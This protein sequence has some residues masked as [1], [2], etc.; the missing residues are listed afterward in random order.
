MKN[1]HPYQTLLAIIGNT[2]GAHALVLFLP[3]HKNKENVCLVSSWCPSQLTVEN[4]VIESG[5]GYIGWVARNSSP[6]LVPHTDIHI[7]SFG[8]YGSKTPDIQ[9]FLAIPLNGGGVLAMDSLIKDDF[10]EDVQKLFALFAQLIPQLQ[11]ISATSSLSLQVSTYFYALESLHILRERYSS[12]S[13]YLKSFLNIISDST[14]FEYVSFASCPEDAKSYIVECENLPLIIKNNEP[15]ELPMQTGM[16]GWVLKN[17]ESLY[18]DGIAQPSTPIYGKIKDFPEFPAT[19]CVAIQV[20]RVTCAVLCL[21]SR[22]SH[23]LSP[24]LRSFVKIASGELAQMLERL[25]LRYK[26]HVLSK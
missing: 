21:A 16:L 25:S 2:F 11:I 23:A 19:I 7:G 10:D 15:V 17:G 1:T 24:E 9:T 4:S 13:E 5:K 3:D 14:G 26:V 22:S 20:D 12:W 6:L 8:Y 18:N